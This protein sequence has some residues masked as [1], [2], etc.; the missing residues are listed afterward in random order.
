M[1]MMS[2]DWSTDAV[3]FVSSES[4]VWPGTRPAALDSTRRVVSS[5]WKVSRFRWTVPGSWLAKIEVAGA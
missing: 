2:A 5:R 4:K 3:T 1:L